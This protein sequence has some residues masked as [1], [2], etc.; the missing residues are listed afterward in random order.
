MTEEKKGAE[1]RTTGRLLQNSTGHHAR[2]EPRKELTDREISLENRITNFCRHNTALIRQIVIKSK[3]VLRG[4]EAT[5]DGSL[6]EALENYEKS[7]DLSKIRVPERYAPKDGD[8]PP[9][10]NHLVRAKSVYDAWKA[11]GY[12]LWAVYHERVE[13][14][15]RNVLVFVLSET[16]PNKKKLKIPA[17][18]YNSI[19]D[20]V[21][22]TVTLT[23]G[24]R[25]SPMGA[26]Y[27]QDTVMLEKSW[28]HEEIKKARHCWRI[29]SRSTTLPRV[30]DLSEEQKKEL[31][32]RRFVFNREMDVVFIHIWAEGDGIPGFPEKEWNPESVD[33][34]TIN[35]AKM[36]K[37]DAYMFN[38]RFGTAFWLTQGF[39]LTTKELIPSLLAEGYHLSTFYKMEM[40][41]RKHKRD[42][43]T[44]EV[45]LDDDKK[46]IVMQGK[47]LGPRY[48]L[49][50]AKK[51]RAEGKLELPRH[52]Q[53]YFENIIWNNAGTN[54]HGGIDTS[55]KEEIR[56]DSVELFCGHPNRELLPRKDG[57]YDLTPLPK[58]KV[59]TE[60]SRNL[61]K[62]VAKGPLKN[63]TNFGRSWKPGDRHA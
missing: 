40:Y 37:L 22:N 36:K 24:A 41:R 53:E 31:L 28:K 10:K 2:P 55:T 43:K 62:R 42:P 12:K 32:K 8:F 45:M 4:F 18:A 63:R 13:G 1:V 50:Y 7:Y 34:R 14:Y 5:K 9:A 46:P 44:Q 47:Y 21:W 25:K 19:K 11:E 3:S 6:E 30:E 26:L 56:R 17:L 23:I 29:G 35:Y 58:V 15:F 61:K 54:S 49:V 57:T 60:M 51:P 27:R 59:Q 33:A 39:L 52:F 20:G 38:G 48:T 16:Q